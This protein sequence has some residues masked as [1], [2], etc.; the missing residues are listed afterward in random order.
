[1]IREV[2]TQHLPK[3]APL[4]GHWQVAHAIKRLL[5]LQELGP[6]P[7][8]DGLPQQDERSVRAVP[9]DTRTSARGTHPPHVAAEVD[10]RIFADVAATRDLAS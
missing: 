1:M 6:H 7:L 5:D 2:A 8:G 4:L 10:D 3:P 9:A